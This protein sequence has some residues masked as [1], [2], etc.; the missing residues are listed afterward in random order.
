MYWSPD[1][2]RQY[3]HCF[4]LGHALTVLVLVSCQ[5][6]WQFM[7][8]I[9]DDSMC[10]DVLK[11]TATVLSFFGSLEVTALVSKQYFH[12]LVLFWIFG[13]SVLILRSGVLVS[14]LKATVLVLV[15]HLRSLSHRWTL[16]HKCLASI[17]III[18]TRALLYTRLTLSSANA[19][20]INK[21]KNVQL[22]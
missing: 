5:E 13:P 3:F 2:S 18:T 12:Y 4:G 15:M 6:I 8:H 10:W 16:Y 22:N 19:A 1:V 14:I 20:A 9:S 21:D 11:F 7:K 17:F